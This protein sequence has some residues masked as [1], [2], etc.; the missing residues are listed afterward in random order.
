MKDLQREILKQVASGTL[1]AEEGAARLEALETEPTTPSGSRPTPSSPAGTGVKQVRVVN[2]F[3]NTEIIGDPSVS[4]AVAE[5]P[6][7]ARQ[8]GDTMIIE[9]SPLSD[10]ASFEF[11]RPQ[12]LIRI[13][14]VDIGGNLTVR[15]NPALPLAAKTQAGNLR[16]AG[17]KGAVAAEVQAGN[18]D[19]T[20]FRGPMNLKVTAGNIS[21]RG[22]LDSGASAI[23]CQMGEV[24]VV[25]DKTSSVRIRAR[26]TLGEIS[27][28]NVEPSGNSELTIGSG[29]GTLDCDCTMGTIRI[30][31][32]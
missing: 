21:A 4:F 27:F 23:R 28:E 22:S 13:P 19:L 31:V 30:A 5:G 24:R 9:Q 2:R 7:K 25:L 10:E 26:T 14:R 32:E 29:A 16:I 1:S 20:D 18:C 3:G 17:V 8:E 12:A 11:S 6:H 15:M